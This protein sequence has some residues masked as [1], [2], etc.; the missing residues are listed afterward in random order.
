MVLLFG[1]LH[2]AAIQAII[3]VNVI[4]FFI[5]YNLYDADADR[6]K[7][8]YEAGNAVAKDVLERIKS[9]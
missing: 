4:S 6:L 9:L 5:D 3:R 2:E 7:V 1:S 8:A